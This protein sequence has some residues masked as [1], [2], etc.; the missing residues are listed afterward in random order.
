MPEVTTTERV[1]GIAS[2]IKQSIVPDL[3]GVKKAKW[4]QQVLLENGKRAQSLHKQAMLD[5]RLGLR[6]E[7]FTVLKDNKVYPG[8][9]TR[10][11]Y[12]DK[13]NVSVECPTPKKVHKAIAE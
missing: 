4:D 2:E 12:Y 11:V 9:D 5:I 1:R 7:S 10:D 6:D 13:W 3:L 8:T